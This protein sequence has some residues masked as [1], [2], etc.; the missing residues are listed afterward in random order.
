[1]AGPRNLPRR[2]PEGEQGFVLIAAIWL[3]VLAGA[4]VAVMMLRGMNDARAAKSEGE[5]LQQKLALDGAMDT[6]VADRLFNGSRSR[7]SIAP[8][9]G[10]IEIDGIGVQ[11]RSTSES[12]RLDL[13]VADLALIDRALQGLGVSGGGRRIILGRLQARRGGAR[14]L[15]V[16]ADV[17][18]LLAE[19][20]RDG[21]VC[22]ADMMTMSS[23]LAQPQANRMPS[24]LAFALATP[25]RA[26]GAPFQAG[27]AQRLEMR[28]QGGVARTVILRVSGQSGSG[29]ATSVSL[30][31]PL[32]ENSLQ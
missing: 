1:V 25:G 3:L 23:G 26:D 16:W 24:Q 11:L 29:M 4:I 7:W 32:C 19:A 9:Q 2:I 22:L 10:S 28:T 5:L 12:G 30:F 27:E 8:A 18:A 21:A 31:R 6:I 20:Q 17:D 15:A 14:T 13:N